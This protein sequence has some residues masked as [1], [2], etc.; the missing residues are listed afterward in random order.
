MPWL[1]PCFFHQWARPYQ[2]YA[3][4]HGHAGWP[5]LRD[6]LVG[7][8]D[9]DRIGTLYPDLPLLAPTI[10]RSGRYIGPLADYPLPFDPLP[11]LCSP[12]LYITL[13]SVPATQ[14]VDA[15][16]SAVG[17]W[18]GSVVATRGGRGG[19]WPAHW[20][21][22]NY[23]DP[24]QVCKQVDWMAWLFHAGNGSSYQLLQSW[25]AAP[26]HCAGAVA[27][28]FH[29]EQQWNA[30]HLAGLGAVRAIG[31]L[32]HLT[33][34]VIQVLIQPPETTLPLPPDFLVAELT[35]YAHAPQRA[36]KEILRWL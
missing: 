5:D 8:R 1:A 34:S 7:D 28:P 20:I 14:F 6:Y 25:T 9:G 36:A 17:D 29:A 26:Q 13:G 10:P 18:P 3:R 16:V 19:D 15:L 12:V 22:V 27:L 33:G 21:S 2:I 35:A 11:T 24:V 23:A 4:A 30:D 31:S 32:H